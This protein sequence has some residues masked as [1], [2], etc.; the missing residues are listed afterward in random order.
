L[1][2]T[3]QLIGFRVID[4]SPNLSAGFVQAFQVVSFIAILLVFISAAF[5]SRSQY[6]DV[7]EVRDYLAVRRKIAVLKSQL[8]SD[9]QRWSNLSSEQRDEIIA[10]RA[11]IFAKHQELENGTIEQMGDTLKNLNQM[12]S[13]YEERYPWL[14]TEGDSH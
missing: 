8:S 9:D 4:N 11:R 3:G 1:I 7:L 6:F 10:E 13:E 5:E 2:V 12:L 14:S